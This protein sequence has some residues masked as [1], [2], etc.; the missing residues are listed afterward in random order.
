MYSK[1][2]IFGHPIHPMVVAYP[3]ALY[4]STFVALLLYQI[5]GDALWFR[6]GLIANIAGVV[7]ALVAAVPGFLDWALGIPG[8]TRAKGAGLTHMLLN[9]SALI[10]FALNALMLAGQWAV[11]QPSAGIGVILALVGLVLTVGAGFFGWT[12][13]QKHHVG[14]ELTPEQARLEPSAPPEAAGQRVYRTR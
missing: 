4:T 13:I 7:M 12:L 14:V 10:V 6:V 1:V 11:T 5:T 2:K 8:G 3:I 9:V